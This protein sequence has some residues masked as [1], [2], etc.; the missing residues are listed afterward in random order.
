[1]EG[2][3]ANSGSGPGV[4]RGDLQNETEAKWEHLSLILQL[5]PETLSPLL[6]I[7]Q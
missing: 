7:F 4:P 2:P 1:M 6:L 3:I 5:A